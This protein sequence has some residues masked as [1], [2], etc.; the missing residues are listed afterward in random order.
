MK[1]FQAQAA[2]KGSIVNAVLDEFGVEEASY[3]ATTK[4]VKAD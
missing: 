3:E 4:N 2:L 1:M